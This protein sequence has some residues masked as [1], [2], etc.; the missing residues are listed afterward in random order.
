MSHTVSNKPRNNKFP[1]FSTI[2]LLVLMALFSSMSLAQD[3]SASVRVLTHSSFDLPFDLLEQFTADTGLQV[4][5][6]PA[7]DAGEVVNRAILLSG[8]PLADV[9]FGVDNNLLPRAAAEGVFEPYASP[10]LESVPADLQFSAQHLVT[11]VDVGFV[12]FNYDRAFF[13][14]PAAPLAPDSLTDLVTPDYRGLTIVLD[15]ASSSPG[16]AFLLTTIARFGEKDSGA[17]NL[18]LDLHTEDEGYDWLDYW[19]DLRD[20][21]V[22]VSEGWSEAYYSLFSIYGGDRPI[23]L[24]YATSPAAEVIFADEPLSESP[25]ANLFC[26]R[27]A[28]RQIEAAGILSGAANPDGARKFIDFLL[29]EQVQQAIPEAMFVYPVRADVPLPAEFLQ[30]GDR[31]AP[32][33]IAELDG[34][35]VADNQ[36]RWLTQ[37]TQVVQQGRAPE[38][39]R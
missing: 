24:S 20:N 39:V 14:D 15:P 12:N 38:D 22:L 37:W 2:M 19:A 8:R 28:Y 36:A 35:F 6:L 33:Q 18:D 17:E 29:S 23:V 16:L 4:D 31:P 1:K 9:L 5:L 3:R 32:E 7:G 25:T 21:D 13:A 10:L 26:D 30:H 27:C 11:P 34:Q